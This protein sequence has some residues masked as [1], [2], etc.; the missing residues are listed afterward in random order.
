M[1][2]FLFNDVI[3]DRLF[4]IVVIPLTLEISIHDDL[5]CSNLQGF[6]RPKFN[7][8]KFK[9]ISRNPNFYFFSIPPNYKITGIYTCIIKNPKPVSAKIG[10][11][12]VKQFVQKGLLT[13]QKG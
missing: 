12:L 5:I 10:T 1:Q 13:D 4:F 9:T 3:D 2:T 6:I 8:N 11:E 7:Q